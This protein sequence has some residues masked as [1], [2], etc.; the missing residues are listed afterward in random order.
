MARC[1]L[2]THVLSPRMRVH[3]NSVR[4]SDAKRETRNA[5]VRSWRVGSVTKPTL[6]FTPSTLKTLTRSTFST[7]WRDEGKR[8]GRAG[9]LLARRRA[10]RYARNLVAACAF[11]GEI[12]IYR[13]SY[14]NY[15]C[16]CLKDVRQQWRQLSSR[17]I[18]A[19]LTRKLSEV[20]SYSWRQSGFL[21]P[22]L[23]AM[24]LLLP[25]QFRADPR[26]TYFGT[27]LRHNTYASLG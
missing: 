4:N 26:A 13:M 11:R 21:Y 15:L 9:K 3:Y 12:Y 16:F 25:G 10:A 18:L 14:N 17:R 7:V 5:N 2:T 22:C 6:P 19:H 20:S 27:T 8:R 23:L 1:F 24:E